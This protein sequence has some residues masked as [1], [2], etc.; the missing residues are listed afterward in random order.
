MKKKTKRP[1]LLRPGILSGEKIFP[2][3]AAALFFL[4]IAVRIFRFGT[5]PGGMNQDGAMAAVDAKALAVY[6]TDRLGMR[7]PV[8]LT[9]WGFGQMSALLSYLEAPFIRLFGL[10]AF[11][12]R[13]PALLVSLAGAAAL[14][15]FTKTA[16]GREPALAVLLVTAVSPWHIMQSRWAIDCNLFPH[17]LAAGLL[18][19]LSGSRNTGG[20]RKLLF[21]SAAAV[22]G[23]SMYCYGISLYTVPVFLLFACVYLLCKNELSPGCAVLCAVIYLITAGPFLLCMM[24]NFFGWE[25][26]ET[27]FFTIPYFPGSIRSNDILFFSKQPLAQL[28]ANC[29]C[30]AGILLQR[31]N[32]FICNE[33][34]GFGTLFPF[35]VPFAVIGAGFLLRRFR[36]N[37]G[38]ALVWLLFLTGLLDGLITANVNIN[39]I[40]L[41]FYPL[42]V[43]TGAGLCGTVGFFKRDAV[44]L[45]KTAAGLITVLYLTGF[46]MFCRSY[47]TT[48]AD[49]I[50]DFFMQDFGEALT[51]VKDT[52]A[53]KFCITP[54]AQYKGFWYV[55][56]LL[57]LF[58]HDVDAPFYQ[59]PAF[60]DR[61]EF[62]NLSPDEAPDGR[63]VYVITDETL[64]CFDGTPYELTQYGRFYTAVP[65]K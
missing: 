65:D 25:T 62:R 23:L 24:I 14:F 58:Y 29:R 22:F 41:I 55:S 59:D 52:E 51:A 35:S 3:A 21:C 48:Y 32:G 4:L 57:T 46:G 64:G 30:T 13:L 17:F 45:A 40:N 18:L 1:D 10:S 49:E 54:D 5:V 15:L 38:A 12:A 43:F 16:F 19:L 27:P 8:H 33:V 53:E 31:Y 37:T 20:K 47:F 11:S 7:Y 26:I 44:F 39:R 9:A 34:R 56:E 61:Y 2:A 60:R 63:T 36:K 6:G 42:I 50:S 28:A